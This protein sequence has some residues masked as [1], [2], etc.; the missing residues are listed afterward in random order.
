LVPNKTDAV[1]YLDSDSSK[2]PRWARVT[3]NVGTT[4]QAGIVEYMVGPLPA[5]S[6]TQILPLT[7][8][9]NSGRNFIQNP[10]PNYE[11][12]LEWFASLGHEVSDVVD[13]LLGEVILPGHSSHAPPLMAL[14]RPA[15]FENGTVSSWATVHAPGRDFDAWSL[16]PQGLYCHFTISG[17][18]SSKWKINEW[19]Y[20]GVL[21]SSTEEFRKAWKNGDIIKQKP[22]SDGKWTAS[23]PDETGILGREKNTPVMVQPDGPRYK[24]D[25]EENHISWMGYSFYLA[26]RQA[27]GLGLWDVTFKNERILY[28]LGL[29]EA[30]A[31][32]AGNDPMSI[33]MVWLDTLFGMGFN[34]YEL[35]P[36]YDCPSYATYLPAT[37][38]QGEDT[39]TRNNSIC[40]FEYT[41]DHAMSR[42]TTPTHVTV[43]RNNYLVVR[44]VATGKHC[45][46]W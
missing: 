5:S 28:E 43:S 42:H 10:L 25:R 26:A 7:F 46:V 39:V 27:T 33:G 22:N 45:F 29:Q 24:I 19:F 36:G 8:P 16:L 44:T 41:A 12:I 37:F 14:A 21:Y 17:R 9:Y 30:M 31:H 40:I 11:S 4:Q 23:H 2:P 32:Y 6:E 20:N 35:V 15:A 18:D 3:I 1:K 13:D 34:M 38:H